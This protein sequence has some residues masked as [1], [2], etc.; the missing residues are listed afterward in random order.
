MK[1][2]LVIFLSLLF[3]FSSAQVRLE[4]KQAKA[5][6]EHLNDI[7][8]K[9]EKFKKKLGLFNLN[10]VTRKQLNWNN[11]LAKV[12][13][14]RAKDMAK[15]N[16]FDHVNPDGKGP[17]YYIQKSGYKLNP[18][19]LKNKKANNFESIAW[20]WPTAKAGIEG[21][22]IGKEAPGYYHRKHLLGMDEWNSS[23]Y[24]IGIGFVTVGKKGKQES[25]LCVIIAKHD[26]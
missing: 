6:F 25:Y 19:W 4:K 9:P 26:S 1:Y 21:L 10:K 8:K 20:N 5:A 24:D 7:R 3:S 12:A 18:N 23:L 17:N 11:Q 2:Q 16:Y 13:E 22:I 15:R 14:A